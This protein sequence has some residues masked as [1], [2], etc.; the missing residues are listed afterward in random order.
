MRG[1]GCRGE[2]V[3]TGR[4]LD[5]GSVIR[6]WGR[7][8]PDVRVADGRKQGAFQ[9][10]CTLALDMRR[11]TARMSAEP[12]FDGYEVLKRVR[13]EPVTDWYLARQR[14][15][16]RTVVIKALVPHVAPDSPF[17]A[18]LPRE[19][20]LLAS[21]RH[22]NIV[23]LYDFVDRPKAAWLVLE[24][25]DGLSLDQWLKEKKRLPVGVALAI[26][27][28]L[29]EALEVIH[30]QGIVHGDLQPRNILIA[31][32]GSVKLDN[33]FAAAERSDPKAAQ[34]VEGRQGFGPPAYMSPEQVLGEAL[35]SRSDLFTLGTVLFEMLTGKRPF[36]AEDS[37]TTAQRIRR[38]PPP[39]LTRLVPEA[40]P[41]VE[42]LIGRALSKFPADRFSSASEMRQ[43]AL[44]CAREYGS[45]SNA[46]LIVGEFRGQAPEPVR[47]RRPRLT[48]PKGKT[49]L[50]KDFAVLA[51]SALVYFT[52]VAVLTRVS[53]NEDG[54]T[55]PSSAGPLP[56]VPRE[57]AFLRAVVTPWAHI[58][59]DGEHIA[60]T[61]FAQPIPLSPGVHH[62]RFEHPD[63]TSEERRI[64]LTPGQ[65]LLLDVEMAL[66]QKLADP[67]IDLLSPP[68]D[69]GLGP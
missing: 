9:T 47:S 64:E 48:P 65:T 26:V 63:A 66:R 25:V 61:P 55:N 19:A 52:G 46:A 12:Q 32:S 18:P 33:F 40:K 29:L 35:D 1:A 14:S 17:A 7:G 5:S 37:R 4:E 31:R 3:S 53:K 60:T 22:P 41:S 38:E 50:A 59:V 10:G 39:A 20:R 28:E 68:A 21:L 24:H 69:A 36:D 13:S 6:A 58:L 62:V 16:G 56:L 30:G 54:K 27:L 23:Q 44:Q 8:F 42:R 57:P 2:V 11:S 34:L 51:T 15:L 67:A 49:Q 43:V 45:G